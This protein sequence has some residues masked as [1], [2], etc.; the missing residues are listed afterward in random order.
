MYPSIIIMV[1]LYIIVLGARDQSATQYEIIPESQPS[2]G[3]LKWEG[4]IVYILGR[5][6]QGSTPLATDCL[7]PRCLVSYLMSRMF[8]PIPGLISCAGVWVIH[9]LQIYHNIHI[10]MYNYF[11]P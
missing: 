3:K 9:V 5:R 2:E 7:R 10:Y 11:W 8:R 1:F 6:M 4:F